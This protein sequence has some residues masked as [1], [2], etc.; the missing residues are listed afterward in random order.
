[1]Q[2]RVEVGVL[3]YLNKVVDPDDKHHIVRML[4]CFSWR[5][6]LCLVFELL[7]VNLYELLK[8]N[9]FKGLSLGLLAIFTAQVTPHFLPSCTSC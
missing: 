4:D 8:H 6:H 9:H 2:A 5:K 3:Q 1:V 7:S